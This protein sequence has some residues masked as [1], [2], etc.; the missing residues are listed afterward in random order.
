MLTICVWSGDVDGGRT[1]VGGRETWVEEFKHI[2]WKE[3]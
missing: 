1:E 3:R 2:E